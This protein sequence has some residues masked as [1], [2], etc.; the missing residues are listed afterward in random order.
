MSDRLL[1][2]PSFAAVPIRLN[3]ECLT[4]QTLPFVDRRDVAFHQP[5]HARLT[6]TVEKRRRQE[7]GSVKSVFLLPAVCQALVATTGV[8]MSS[9]SS[10]RV[11]NARQRFYE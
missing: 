3:E 1:T 6:Q 5:A 11:Q 10:R 7:K 4:Q 2:R 8:M 9:I